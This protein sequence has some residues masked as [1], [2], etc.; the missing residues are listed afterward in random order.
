ML[1]DNVHPDEAKEQYLSNL[2]L[3]QIAAR[4]AYSRHHQ[5]ETVRDNSS[6]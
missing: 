6:G 3:R 5:L 4:M 2:T 1:G